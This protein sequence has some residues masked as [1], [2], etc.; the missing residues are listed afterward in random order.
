MF[1]F[2]ERRDVPSTTAVSTTAADTTTPPETETT[3]AEVAETAGHPAVTT[4]AGGDRKIIINLKD[5]YRCPAT[6]TIIFFNKV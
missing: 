6:G 4:S 3:P 5:I 2:P 1:I